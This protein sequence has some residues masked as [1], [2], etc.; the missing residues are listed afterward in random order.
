MGDIRQAVGA[1]AGAAG[2]AQV[3]D[4]CL[5]ASMAHNRRPGKAGHSPCS[6]A[7][8]VDESLAVFRLNHYLEELDGSAVATAAH[9]PQLFRSLPFREQ[10]TKAMRS[11]SFHEMNRN[12]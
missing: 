9:D 8:G 11:G 2:F 5:H 1:E 10:V 3:R 4:V 12:E 6:L 7:V